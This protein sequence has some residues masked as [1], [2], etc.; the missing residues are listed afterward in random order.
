MIC[1]V[2]NKVYQITEEKSSR[3]RKLRMFEKDG[4]NS[5]KLGVG[6]LALST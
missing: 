2:E 5:M 6:I 4:A 3:F 1:Y